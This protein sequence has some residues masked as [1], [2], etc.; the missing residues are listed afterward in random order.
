MKKIQLLILLSLCFNSC[1]NSDKKMNTSKTKLQYTISIKSK[2]GNGYG[3]IYTCKIIE[4]SQETTEDKEIR[5][6]ILASDRFDEKYQLFED[7][8][9]TRLNIE[10]EKH[11]ENEPYGV[12]PI[13]GFVDVN[14]T[15][16]KIT[17][18]E[19]L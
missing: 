10:F 4:P 12:M 1:L 6:T 18:V 2:M 7:N 9:T 8:E 5:I 19:R 11:K 13:N 14:K 16:W 15:S 3:T 17:N